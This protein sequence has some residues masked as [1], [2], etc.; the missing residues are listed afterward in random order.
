MSRRVS[1]HPSFLSPSPFSCPAASFRCL[2]LRRRWLVWNRYSHFPTKILLTPDQTVAVAL[3]VA[4]SALLRSRVLDF[5][6]LGF[7]PKHAALSRCGFGGAGSMGGAEGR[8]SCLRRRGYIRVTPNKG[9]RFV[10]IRS[11]VETGTTDF[12]H[13][14]GVFIRKRS[15]KSTRA[16]LLG[17][18]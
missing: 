5:N 16:S 8:G 2:R 13:A 14:E 1:R 7:Q 12:S 10:E 6:L 15:S 18:R 9:D 11:R 4:V 17:K 3:G